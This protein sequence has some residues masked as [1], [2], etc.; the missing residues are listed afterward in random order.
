MLRYFLI[1]IYLVSIAYLTGLLRWLR[2][3]ESA[4]NVRDSGLIHGREDPLEEG[5]AVHSCILAWRIP[6][7]EE[8]NGL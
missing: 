1:S 3:E 8:A 5:M 4:C 6:W 7:T 2:G